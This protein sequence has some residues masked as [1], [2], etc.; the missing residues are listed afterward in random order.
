[1]CIYLLA[2]V[3]SLPEI[4]KSL[5]VTTCL[6]SSLGFR[7]LLNITEARQVAGGVV[8]EVTAGAA[9]K[10]DLNVKE[11]VGTWPLMGDAVPRMQCR[12][13]DICGHL[14]VLLGICGFDGYI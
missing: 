6:P 9:N 10:A 2:L 12:G 3:H 13:W 1:M 14:W 11:P 8:K 7:D 5:Q 4:L